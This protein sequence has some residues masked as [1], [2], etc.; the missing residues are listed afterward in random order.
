MRFAFQIHSFASSLQS[1]SS[2]IEGHTPAVAGEPC[3]HA[4]QIVP[5]FAFEN[6]LNIA[7]H[8]MPALS[9]KAKTKKCGVCVIPEVF[10]AVSGAPGRPTTAE[11]ELE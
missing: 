8:A 9:A 4:I 7:R 1:A 11:A 10:V 6:I 5:S 3:I 2:H